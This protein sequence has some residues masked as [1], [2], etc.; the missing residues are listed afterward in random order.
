VKYDPKHPDMAAALRPWGNEQERIHKMTVLSMKLY[1]AWRRGEIQSAGPHSY[2]PWFWGAPPLD[3]VVR[4]WERSSTGVVSPSSVGVIVD[5]PKPPTPQDP[6]LGPPQVFRLR[7]QGGNVGIQ[8]PWS[9]L[10]EKTEPIFCVEKLR[11]GEYPAL[12]PA[13]DRGLGVPPWYLADMRSGKVTGGQAVA[14]FA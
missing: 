3:Q 4:G 2:L 5:P 1:W 9:A 10:T 8:V 11:N 6:T 7:S 13:K 12:Y 14:V